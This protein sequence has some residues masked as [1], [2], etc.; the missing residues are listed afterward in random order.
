M[1]V[2]L[3]ADGAILFDDEGALHAETPPFTPRSTVGAGDAL[4]SGFLSAADDRE[5]SLTEA[6]AWGA[7]ATRLPGSR[8]P[9]PED[10]D[11]EAVRLHERFDK[12]RQLKGEVPV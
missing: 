4:L 7:A 9:K 3:G 2:S 5:A 12:E 1:L 11:R 10:L 6:V 8:G